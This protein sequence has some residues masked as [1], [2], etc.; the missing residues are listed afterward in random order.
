[1]R[2]ENKVQLAK[3]QVELEGHLG[4]SEVEHLPLA[5]VVVPGSWDPVPH[6][7]YFKEPASPSMTLLL[8]LS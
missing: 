1:M 2:T 5:Q 6:Q 7:A 4:G 8:C 3:H